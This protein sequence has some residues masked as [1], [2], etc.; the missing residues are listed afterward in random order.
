L[1]VIVGVVV[2]LALFF[3][4]LR[5]TLFTRIQKSVSISVAAMIF[6]FLLLNTNF[7][8]QLL[9]YQGGNELAF[10]TRNEVDARD[11]YFWEDNYSSSYNFYTATLRKPFVDSSFQ[12]ERKTWLLFDI[13]DEEEIKKKYELGKRFSTVDYEITRLDLKFVN[14]ST[15]E[16][17]C[18]QMVIAE[19]IGKLN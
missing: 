16:S 12:K 14:P 6:A 15:R 17:R 3:Y 4:F 18:T 5:S 2:F 8:P 19:I 10:G 1:A 11:V 9:K 7:Y 13:R